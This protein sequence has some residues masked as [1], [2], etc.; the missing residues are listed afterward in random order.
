VGILDR[1]RRGQPTPEPIAAPT[2]RAQRFYALPRGAHY[3]VHGE[4][5]CQEAIREL[6]A[7]C[8]PDPGD[9]GRLSCDVMLIAEPSNRW[10]PHAIAVHASTGQVGYLARDDAPEF[11]QVFSE[12][13][14]LGY[15]GATCGAVMTG[16]EPDKPSLGVVLVVSHARFC[17]EQLR[18][19]HA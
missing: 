7:T 14:R 2:A 1:L 15:D 19:D 12:L 18:R 10:D 3:A 13:R 11:E 6:H 8:R 17:W 9:N 16:G 5:H 4:S